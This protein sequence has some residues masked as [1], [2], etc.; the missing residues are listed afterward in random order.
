MKVWGAPCDSTFDWEIVVWKFQSSL[1]SL[2][3]VGEHH[4]L[5]LFINCFVLFHE[6]KLGLGQT[7]NWKICKPF[8]SRNLHDTLFEKDEEHF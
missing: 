4:T 5:L 7:F 1:S 8:P 2:Q 6:F 3:Q